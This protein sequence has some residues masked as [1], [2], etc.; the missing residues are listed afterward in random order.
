MCLVIVFYSGRFNVCVNVCS[1]IVYKFY[2][3]W[4][5]MFWDGFLFVLLNIVLGSLYLYDKECLK[6]WWI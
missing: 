5:V 3:I 4:W 2:I 6:G 1:F